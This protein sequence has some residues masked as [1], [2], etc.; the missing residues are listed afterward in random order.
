MNE[1]AGDEPAK[2]SELLGIDHNDLAAFEAGA[3]RIDA[4]LLFRIAKSLGARPDYFFRGY[5]EEKPEPL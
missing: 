5:A 3:E 4:D 2:F 1:L